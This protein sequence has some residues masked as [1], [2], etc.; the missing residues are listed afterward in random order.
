MFFL[1]LRSDGATYR[2]RALRAV[3][4]PLSLRAEQ[5]REPKYGKTISF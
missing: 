1:R 3:P 5:R 4:V 2:S